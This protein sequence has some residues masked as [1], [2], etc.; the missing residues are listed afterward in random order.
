MEKNE[1]IRGPK[2]SKEEQKQSAANSN[3]KTQEEY[4]AQIMSDEAKNQ[5]PPR[6]PVE[7]QF[8]NTAPRFQLQR[9][10]SSSSGITAGS[11]YSSSKNQVQN[12]EDEEDEEDAMDPRNFLNNMYKNDTF[13]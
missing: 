4:L 10:Q 2:K 11:A 9:P 1:K 13:L 6:T 12:K 7:M 5:L 8:R 3:S